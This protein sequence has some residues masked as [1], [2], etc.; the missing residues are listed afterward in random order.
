MSAATPAAITLKSTDFLRFVPAANY[1]GAATALSANLIE[2]GP[3]ITSGATL[4]LTGATG[5]ATHISSATVALSHTINAV[6]D[7]PIATIT[8]ASYNA[9]EQTSLSLKN[10]GLSIS[11]IDAGGGSVTVTLSVGEGILTVTP[12]TSGAI[13]S[14]SG[15]A[16]VTIAGTVAQINALLNT[17]GTSTVSY[18]N[19]S[20]APPASTS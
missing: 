12:G 4:D 6:N 11:D 3:T 2:T 20:D 15:T 8:P 7:A 19:N 16:S 14:N 10:N 9:T 5:G 18:I 13:I 17:N 1:N